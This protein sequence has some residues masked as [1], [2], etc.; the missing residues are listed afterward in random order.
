MKI[1]NIATNVTNINELYIAEAADMP[2]KTAEIPVVKRKNGFIRFMNSGWGV[3]ILC[4]LISTAIT[5][6]I[7]AAGK[8]PTPPAAGPTY[9]DFSFSYSLT[10]NQSEF[11]PGD[12]FIVYT[13][14]KNEGGAFTVRGS[15]MSFGAEAFLVPHA[16]ENVFTSERRI[17]GFYAYTDDYV[18]KRIESGA[19]GHHSGLFIIPE[20]AIAGDYDLVVTYKGEY[21]IFEKVVRIVSTS[22]IIITP[23][24]TTISITREPEKSTYTIKETVTISF[25]VIGIPRFTSEDITTDVPLDRGYRVSAV[26]TP[27]GKGTDDVS[28]IIGEVE[29]DTFA[30]LANSNLDRAYYTADFEIPANAAA[31]AYDLYLLYVSTREGDDRVA[32]TVAPELLT[33][34]IPRF[35]FHY[36]IEPITTTF[37][38]GNS[39]QINTRITNLGEAFTVTGSHQAFSAE[40]KLLLHHDPNQVIYGEFVYDTNLVTQEIATGQQGQHTG[41]FHIPTDATTGIYDLWLYYGE[42]YYVFEEA[43]SI[44]DPSVLPLLDKI[45]FYEAGVFDRLKGFTLLQFRHRWGEPDE[46]LSGTQEYL[47]ELPNDHDYISII[48]SANGL[49]ENITYTN[50]MKATVTERDGNHL[51]VQPYV[52]EIELS[53]GHAFD[54]SLS[55]TPQSIKDA[56]EVGTVIYVSYVGGINESYPCHFANQGAVTLNPPADIPITPAEVK[57]MAD[58]LMLQQKLP[59]SLDVLEYRISENEESEYYRISYTYLL[60]G[61]STSYQFIMRIDYDGILLDAQYSEWDPD[62]FYALYTNEEVSVARER[63]SERIHAELGAEIPPNHGTFKEEDGKL[64]I[65]V[66][67]ITDCDCDPPCFEGHHHVFY[68]EEVVKPK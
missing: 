11:K 23:S 42:E 64:Y 40:A 68:E 59:V 63:L 45:K 29:W 28:A 2:Y 18:V 47:W 48:F 38:L 5:V 54:V 43:I 39:Y 25:V 60:G 57:A 35:D 49:S 55:N 13:T 1:F 9:S 12:S 61:L 34:T 51:I 16:T 46:I 17:T 15:S 52:G 27:H 30:N 7:I 41:S 50:V 62:A 31:G 66:E 19:E 22:G 36:S 10:P 37:L 33:V 24:E 32:E 26:L 67:L 44:E 21:Q 3:A 20:D 56:I 4:L 6:G 14:V 58:G 8:T 53:S 65:R